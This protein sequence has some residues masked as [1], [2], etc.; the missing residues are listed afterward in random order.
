MPNKERAKRKMKCQCLKPI[1]FTKF[2]SARD[3]EE[4]PMYKLEI[5]KHIT[6]RKKG[7]RKEFTCE[8]S[9]TSKMHHLL[10]EAFGQSGGRESKMHFEYGPEWWAYFHVAYC[11]TPIEDCIVG[12]AES[13]AFACDRALRCKS[14]AST[15]K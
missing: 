3:R 12:L 6:S 5:W 15:W 9:I 14:L 2:L 1:C 11:E 7:A 4:K 13:A 10:N 8:R